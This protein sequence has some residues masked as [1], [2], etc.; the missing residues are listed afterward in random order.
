MTSVRRQSN[1]SQ[2][3][4]HAIGIFK[5]NDRIGRNTNIVE[6]INWRSRKTANCSRTPRTP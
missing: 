3:K 4:A 1:F 2:L 5:T 6:T